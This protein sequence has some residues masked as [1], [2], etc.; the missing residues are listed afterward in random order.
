M[1]LPPPRRHRPPG[2]GTAGPAV[3]SA[4]A[5]RCARSGA[6]ADRGPRPAGWE[7]SGGSGNGGAAEH[8]GLIHMCICLKNH[9]FFHFKC[10]Y[11]YLRFMPSKR[12]MPSKR[13]TVLTGICWI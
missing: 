9:M 10:V 12:N 11:M 1:V 8:M 3:P 6:G 7:A 5:W 13:I 4:R 2:V